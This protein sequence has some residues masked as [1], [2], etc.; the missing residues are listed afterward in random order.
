[1]SSDS[2]GLPRS[3]TYLDLRGASVADA[4][5]WTL[6]PLRLTWELSDGKVVAGSAR[7]L[8]GM[9]AWVYDVSR[10]ALPTAEQLK[11]AGDWSKIAEAVRGAADEFL[12]VVN[13]TLDPGGK[14]SSFW[15]APANCSFS[16]IAT[17]TRKHS[18][19]WTIWV[20]RAR[21]IAC[22]ARRASC[23]RLRES[24]PKQARKLSQSDWRPASDRVLPG[25]MRISAGS[26]WPVR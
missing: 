14:D 12:R 24:V 9:S 7:R 13:G 17:V 21:Q 8:P 2:W 26:C 15:F 16:P 4:L 1:M 23:S 25:C 19:C 11:E 20:I 10:I 22:R 18:N 6:Q 5:E 3:V